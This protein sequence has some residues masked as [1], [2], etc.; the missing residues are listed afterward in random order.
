[1]AI[2]DHSYRR[3]KAGMRHYTCWHCGSERPDYMVFERRGSLL[4]KNC[5]TSTA[6]RKAYEAWFVRDGDEMAPAFTNKE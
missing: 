5:L 6:E 4:C 2:G 1:M 3:D